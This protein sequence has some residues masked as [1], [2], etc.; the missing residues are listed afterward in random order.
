MSRKNV[1]G[2]LALAASLAVTGCMVD[3]QAGVVAEPVA[4]VDVE[5]APEPPPPVYEQEVVVVRPGYSWI[6]GHYYWRGGRW[7]WGRGHWEGARAGY[8]YG[9]GRWEVRGR[10][11]VY[12]EGGWRRR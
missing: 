1:L 7:V 9:P 2:S 8:V 5:A 4:T 10:R 12:V 6:G 11:R 3:G